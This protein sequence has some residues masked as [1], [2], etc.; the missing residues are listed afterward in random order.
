[1]PQ[2]LFQWERIPLGSGDLWSG[3]WGFLVSK[4]EP[5]HHNKALFWGCG[6]SA[7]TTEII[8]VQVVITVINRSCLPS[9]F[10]QLLCSS[11]PL[12]RGAF[13]G[14]PVQARPSVRGVFAVCELFL[15]TGCYHSCVYTAPTIT[16]L[17][18]CHICW[19]IPATTLAIWCS[20]LFPQ[21]QFLAVQSL[22]AQTGRKLPTSTA[23]SLYYPQGFQLRSSLLL[24]HCL[25]PFL[26]EK[27]NGL[28]WAQVILHCSKSLQIAPA[29]NSLV[30]VISAA[31][32][33]HKRFAQ[34]RRGVKGHSALGAFQ[35]H[36]LGFMDVALLVGRILLSQVFTQTGLWTRL[37]ASVPLG[38]NWG[39]CS[40]VCGGCGR[41]VRANGFRH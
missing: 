39:C 30:L 11:T 33:G 27:I 40:R 4:P 36:L 3:L 26:Q 2:G 16:W 31:H 23:P 32:R 35:K 38:V 19:I 6:Q 25:L 18:P 34:W 8:A 5:I 24:N 9:R 41:N 15:C 17:K 1:M 20:K 21:L 12:S 28:K 37:R 7:A 29:I 10:R 14:C 22:V 13:P